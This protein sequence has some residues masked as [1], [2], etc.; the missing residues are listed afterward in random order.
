MFNIAFE[1]DRSYLGTPS[2]SGASA[3]GLT[4]DLMAVRSTLR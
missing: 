4:L 3:V 2:H 1:A